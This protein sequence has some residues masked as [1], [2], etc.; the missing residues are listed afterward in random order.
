MSV[1][2]MQNEILWYEI[3]WNIFLRIFHQIL[4]CYEIFMKLKVHFIME[5][6]ISGQE[7]TKY[8]YQFLKNRVNCILSKLIKG[9][10]CIKNWLWYLS[11]T[12]IF[13][14]A[15][16]AA[17]DGAVARFSLQRCRNFRIQ[18]W[19]NCKNRE[20]QSVNYI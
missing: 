12:S 17:G 14:F 19:E 9:S 15:K 8:K 7:P 13:K 4:T 18:N 3:P 10:I 1:A 11:N 6:C 5:F 16:Y 2:M 20:G